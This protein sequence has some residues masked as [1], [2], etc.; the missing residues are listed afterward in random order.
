MRGL[1]D[2]EWPA[3]A[4]VAARAM[5]DEPYLHVPTG[6]IRFTASPLTHDLY[7]AADLTGRLILIAEADGDFVGVVAGRPPGTVRSPP[8]SITA[9]EIVTEDP[10]EVAFRRVDARARDAHRSLE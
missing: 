6:T 3:A 5:W 8:W 9:E 7:E 10:M 4:G 2:G 1:R